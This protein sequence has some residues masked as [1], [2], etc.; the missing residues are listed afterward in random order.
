M[1]Q[2][3]HD[4]A[5]AAF[6]R[7]GPLAGAEVGFIAKAIDQIR[8]TYNIDPL[9]VA[10]HGQQ[11]GGSLAY[12]VG[13]THRDVVRG[14]AAVDAPIL[15]R[16]PENDPANRLVVF[17]TTAKKANF[18]EQISAAIDELRKLKYAVTIADLGDSARPL[19]AGEFAELTR[20][21][22]SLDKI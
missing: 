7:C 20:W 2:A 5:G 8:E 22:D 6:G 11:A 19:D 18:A 15:G 4:P 10:V 14:V 1:R 13:F 17:A 3:E 16:V 12:I 9:R 21:I